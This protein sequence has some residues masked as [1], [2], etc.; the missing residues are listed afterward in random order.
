MGAP[1]AS[2]R[3]LLASASA[4]PRWLVYS[5]RAAWLVYIARDGLGPHAGARVCTAGG[6]VCSA[7][8]RAVRAVASQ[9]VL[10]ASPASGS[11]STCDATDPIEPSDVPKPT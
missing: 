7:A 2:A 10:A 1:S 8:G 4:L 9:P 6:G 3:P 11:R 5:T